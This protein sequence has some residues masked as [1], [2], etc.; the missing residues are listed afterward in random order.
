MF[1][2]SPR[3][4]DRWTRNTMWKLAQFPFSLSN[5][6]SEVKMKLKIFL[7]GM[8]A[9]RLADKNSARNM[10]IAIFAGEK[11]MSE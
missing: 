11:G 7:S 5:H 6:C 4:V 8:G 10:V 2:S 1:G 9:R 3:Y